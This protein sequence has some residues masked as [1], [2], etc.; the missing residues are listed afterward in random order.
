MMYPLG[1]QPT[2]PY[3]L[4]TPNKAWT[5]EQ[6]QVGKNTFAALLNNGR[7]LG[8]ALYEAVADAVNN[9]TATRISQLAPGVAPAGGDTYQRSDHGVAYKAT[10]WL[11]EL[12]DEERITV[13]QKNATI[14]ALQNEKTNL[15]NEAAAAKGELAA[16]KK[17]HTVTKRKLTMEKNK[18]NQEL[19]AEAD[20]SDSDDP[21]WS[22]ENLRAKYLTRPPKR[23]IDEVTEAGDDD[24]DDDDNM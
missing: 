18:T 20:D 6:E 13:A 24:D 11:K 17:A 7:K 2:L 10:K 9:D 14:T 23:T 4:A 16:E 8:K 5:S 12:F 22:L 1:N 3:D 19:L 21:W 15:Q